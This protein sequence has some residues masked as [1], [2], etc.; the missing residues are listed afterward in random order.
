MSADKSKAVAHYG[1]MADH[2]ALLAQLARYTGKGARPQSGCGLAKLKLAGAECWVE[3][4]A[5]AEEGDGF[6]EPYYPARVTVIQALINGTWID[7]EGIVQS[8]VVERWEAD[9]MDARKVAR[10]EAAIDAA[11][12]AAE[13]ES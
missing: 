6:H 8:S 2:A 4:E 11:I 7:P 10:D 5:E 9:I 1:Q 13:C 12:A 3:Y